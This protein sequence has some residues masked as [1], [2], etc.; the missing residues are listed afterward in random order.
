MA[1]HVGPEESGQGRRY[2]VSVGGHF[3]KATYQVRDIGQHDLDHIPLVSGDEAAVDLF[4][5]GRIELG[6]AAL[7]LAGRH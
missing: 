1:A 4:L 3:G 2:R 7:F 5:E 6:V